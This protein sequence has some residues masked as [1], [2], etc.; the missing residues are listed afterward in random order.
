ML[1]GLAKI[2]GAHEWVACFI[3]GGGE[4]SSFF[5]LSPKG[6]LDNFFVRQVVMLKEEAV[7]KAT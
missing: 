5:I 2:G 4:K 6:V 3:S 1:L 7:P